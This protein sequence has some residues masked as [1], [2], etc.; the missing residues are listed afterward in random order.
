MLNLY[1]KSYDNMIN[2]SKERINEIDSECLIM[3]R[4][5]RENLLIKYVIN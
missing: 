3:N 2:L 4:A 1:L 5:I